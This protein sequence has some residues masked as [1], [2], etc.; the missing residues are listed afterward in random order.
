[1]SFFETLQD[2]GGHDTRRYYG[3]YPGLVLDNTSAEGPHRGRLKV[4][5]PGILE[6]VP[7]GLGDRPLEVRAEPCFPPGFFFLPEPGAQVWVEFVAG[8]LDHA[9]WTGVWYPEGATPPAIGGDA[10]TEAQ[11]LIRTPSGQVIQLED[12]GGAERL[13]LTEEKHQS[14]LT[15]DADGITLTRGQSTLLLKDDALELSIGQS[16]LTLKAGDITLSSNGNTLKLN[17]SG[18]TFNDAPLVLEALIDVLRTHQHISAAPLS[19][20][21]PS[22]DIVPMLMQPGLKSTLP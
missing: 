19:P 10:P 22:P 16:T 1:M 11:K 12:T 18:A 4:Q 15:L 6:E 7:G 13:V 3:K 2:R 8:D 21:T 20:T 17:A 14:T 5:V 9:L